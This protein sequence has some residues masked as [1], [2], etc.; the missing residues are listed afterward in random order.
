MVGTLAGGYDDQSVSQ[1]RT[2]VGPVD[3]PEYEE[4]TAFIYELLAIASS[5]G[6]LNIRTKNLYNLSQMFTTS[7]KKS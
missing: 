7:R 5:E 1:V 4:R 3:N 6:Y 2:C